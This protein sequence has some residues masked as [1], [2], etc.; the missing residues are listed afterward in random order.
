MSLKI[1]LCDLN[2]S[3]NAEKCLS[4][5]SS[6][7]QNSE[8][9]LAGGMGSDYFWD[10]DYLIHDKN[11]SKEILNLFVDSIKKLEKENIIDFNTLGFIDKGNDGPLGMVSFFIAIQSKIAKKFII[12]RPKKLLLK[13]AIK[14]SIL[15]VSDKVL[16]LSDVATTG[17]GIFKAS[18]KVKDYGAKVSG[19][20]VL[21]D[22]TQGANENLQRKGI[23]LFSIFSA[24]KIYSS[25]FV[26]D[27]LKERH[28][29][30]II[31]DFNP[32]L[33]DLGG[34]IEVAVR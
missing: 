19:A 25:K 3:A 21:F 30:R 11:K 26:R 32:R 29:K 31:K 34:N 23:N 15:N 2:I 8:W 17:R 12:I 24:E 13:S 4:I 5:A 20:L 28:K 7:I 22:R 10:I 6:A 9:T 33:I 1:E 18:Q 14:G 16:I 27:T